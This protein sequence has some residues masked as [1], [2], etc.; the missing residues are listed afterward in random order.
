MSLAFPPGALMSILGATLLND[1]IIHEEI[2]LP[3][4]I[5]ENLRQK[6]ILTLG[7]NKD[8]VCV[9]DGIE[10]TVISYNP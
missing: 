7:Q 4:K 5:L 9:K 3:D 6:L 2:F 1:I 10:G 8:H